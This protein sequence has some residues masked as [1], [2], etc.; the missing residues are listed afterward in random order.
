MAF[1]DEI[2]DFLVPQVVDPK[3]TRE[4]LKSLGSSP[5][6][7]T[8][9]V[10]AVSRDFGGDRRIWNALAEDTEET[11]SMLPDYEEYRDAV[12]PFF[13]EEAAKSGRYRPGDRSAYEVDERLA[14]AGLQRPYGTML[15]GAADK[16]VLGDSIADLL[17]R[18]MVEPATR[19]SYQSLVNMGLV[20]PMSLVRDAVARGG[21]P[22]FYPLR[23]LRNLTMSAETGMPK[24]VID[25]LTS[26]G[27]MQAG[28]YIEANRTLAALPFVRLDKKGN[29]QFD[30]K[31]FTRVFG[32]GAAQGPAAKELRQE[33]I[34]M[35]ADPNFIGR[36]ISGI[37]DKTGPYMA[38]A[39]NP[40]TRMASVDDSIME[41]VLTGATSGGLP[42]NAMSSMY[43]QLPVRAL[44]SI[45][46]ITPSAAQE[47]GWWTPRILKGSAASAV[48]FERNITDSMIDEAYSGV[49][50]R[51][52]NSPNPQLKE[53]QEISKRLNKYLGGRSLVD[54]EV[55]ALAAEA[56]RAEN[57]PEGLNVV[58]RTVD[59][60]TVDTVVPEDTIENAMAFNS[61]KFAD[62]YKMAI[63][64]VEKLGKNADPNRVAVILALFGIP[65]A[66][67]ANR[68]KGGSNAV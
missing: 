3:A 11:L 64:A 14:A 31:S 13:R 19:S 17:A 21:N 12:L 47:I 54:P 29:P 53:T 16:P 51:N 9:N 26:I 28:P 8:T 45:M 35:I 24:D 50:G 27:S 36:A 58:R 38:T 7:G 10:K 46:G 37:S 68:N 44:A 4:Y 1:L 63:Q 61:R 40:L 25:T 52:P 20:T 6:F 18:G 67:F 60:R 59:G 57:L 62:R 39:L 34:K 48:P 49:V 2:V 15:R 43:G 23:D 66:Y 55:A 30:L 33:I 42:G 5:L 32:E 22:I 65:A 41:S 56:R